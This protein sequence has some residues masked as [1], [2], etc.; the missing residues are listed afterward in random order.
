LKRMAI[1]ASLA[2]L[3][4]TS[5]FGD[6]PTGEARY[7]VVAIHAH[8]YFH[9][10]GKTSPTDLLD[11]N[12]HA[13]WNTIT[14]EGEARSPSSAIMVLIDLVGPDFTH[15]DGK[16]AVKVTD[17]KKTLLDSV[18]LLDDWF[19]DGRK[20]ALPVIVYGTGCSKLNITATLQGLSAEMVGTATLT[21]SIL[22]E[23]GE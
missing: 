14:G 18:L 17:S 8:L 16:L 20:V 5:V 1:L 2:V 10:T 4:I 19:S 22:F 3:F 9:E 15:S 12:N 13:L 7:S 21:R 23:C 6:K 11:G